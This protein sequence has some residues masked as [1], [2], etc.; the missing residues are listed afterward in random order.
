MYANCN[1]QKEYKLVFG[2]T[3]QSRKEVFSKA[4][5]RLSDFVSADIDE[6]SI[7]D[8][9]PRRLVK[10][11]SEAKME[12]VLKKLPYKRGEDKVIV[13]CADTVAL[14]DGEVRNKPSSDEER[15]RFL[16]S[17]SGSYV[18]CITGVT[19]YNYLTKRR[20]SD[21]TVSRVYYKEMPEEAI[22]RIFEESE[23]IRH[24]CGGF[25]IDCPIM[26]A[27]VEEI[28]G[29]PEN[30]MGIS[31]RNTVDLMERSILLGTAG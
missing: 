2:S 16:R 1:F 4:E 23:V 19:V 8:E 10:K 15:L 11:I 5:I 29:D 17:Y 3:S 12:A 28:E 14:K 22:Q 9:D 30:I 7:T 27:Y 25:A 6:R 24:S 21:V 13:I 26:G 18:D 31:V 20:L